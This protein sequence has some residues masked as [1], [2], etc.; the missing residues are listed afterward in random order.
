MTESEIR[1][2]L[3]DVLP[4]S[5]SQK[6][7]DEIVERLATDETIGSI[8]IHGARVPVETVEAYGLAIEVDANGRAAVVHFSDDTYI[9]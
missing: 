1:T 4:K 6:R 2:V 7:I 3:L 9:I 5:V 8:G